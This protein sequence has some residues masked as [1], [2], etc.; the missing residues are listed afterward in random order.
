MLDLEAVGDH[1]NQ[2]TEVQDYVECLSPSTIMMTDTDLRFKLPR[3]LRELSRPIAHFL[4]LLQ[5]GSS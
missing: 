2:V 1:A 4:K 3:A 5:K